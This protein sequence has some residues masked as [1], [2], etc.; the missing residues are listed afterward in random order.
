MKNVAV[1]FGGKSV[2]HDVSIITGVMALNSIDKEKFTPIPIYVTKEGEWLTSKILFDLD[3][4]KN[5]KNEKLKRVCF[6]QG[7]NILYEIKGKKLKK[8]ES[9]FCV[10]NCLHGER[11]EDGALAGLLKMCDIPQTSSDILPSAISMDKSLSATVLSALKIPTLK[12]IT[13]SSLDDLKK[14]LEKFEF[15]LIVKPNLLGSSIGIGK[16]SDKKSL[17]KAIENA[18]KYG[19]KAIIQPF[20]QD[21]IEINCAVYRDETGELHISECERPIARDKILSFGDKY[22]D[23]KR[24]FPANIDKKLS[25]K[26]KKLSQ[27]IYIGL[28]FSGVI[29]IDYF[30][31]KNKI[32]VNEINSI[33]G[34]LSHYLFF[35]TMK[36]FSK[37]LSSLIMASE[38]KH[39]LSQ[40]KTTEYNSGILS[41]LGSKGAK[42]L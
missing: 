38:K 7:E 36:G 42:R 30:I 33:P 2:E 29:R 11:G 34:S 21:F 35:D 22:K 5:L 17:A 3:E 24:E 1:I 41:S 8:I 12:S 23:G 25:D 15:P 26:I 18:L 13:V 20:L 9:V 28:D 37:M 32:Y 40:G 39:L 27:K 6:V 31:C 16:A 4:Y 10:V 19:E 14:V